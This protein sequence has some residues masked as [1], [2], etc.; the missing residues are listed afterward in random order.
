[1]PLEFSSKRAVPRDQETSITL[2]SISEKMAFEGKVVIITGSSSGLGQDAALL[3]GSQGA[4]VTIHGQN[5]GRIE[6]TLKL[7]SS[8]S[9]PAENVHTVRGPLEEE[10]IVRA[11]IDETVEKFGQIDFVINNAGCYE[12]SGAEEPESI[13]TYD[14]V[15]AVNLRSPIL[16]TKLAVPHLE[17]TKGCVVNV[18]S[19][20]SIMPIYI[21]AY[22]STSKAA[23]DH[24]TKVAALRLAPKR[25]P[26][27]SIRRFWA[28]TVREHRWI[29]WRCTQNDLD[30]RTPLARRASP[31]EINSVVEFL[32]SP[33]SSFITGS[34]IVAD[35][36]FLSGVLPPK[37]LNL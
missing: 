13:D 6:E 18:S 37:S 15:M 32:C 21:G 22:Y 23:L 14:Y 10:S 2:K 30:S 31:R 20:L 19:M 1:M 8:K 12:K 33:A 16:L 7:L 29:S 27:T 9:I 11:L 28:P 34:V 24:Y 36:G 35:G 5:P 26:G 17:K 3:F 4:K 25:K